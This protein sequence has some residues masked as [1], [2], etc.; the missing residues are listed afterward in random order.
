MKL[1]QV[2]VSLGLIT[3]ALVATGCALPGSKH[4]L[5]DEASSVVDDRLVGQWHMAEAKEDA[6]S[7]PLQITI[8]RV[9]DH[10]NLLEVV[11]PTL[12]DSGFVQI[13]RWRLFPAKIG[14][15]FYVSQFVEEKGK[16]DGSSYFIWH[17]EF[18]DETTAECRLFD[19]EFI[20]GAIERGELNGRFKRKQRGKDPN[21][22]LPLESVEIT[23]ETKDLAAFVAK[24]GPAAFTKPS[25]EFKRIN[26]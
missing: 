7:D 13:K 23:A 26:R 14:D 8:G 5:S 6:K 11:V 21:E 10:P 4:P 1:K 16:P 18:K 25:L 17:Y 20:A 24:H 2:G 12:D 9:P 22:A 3:W 15:H 19:G